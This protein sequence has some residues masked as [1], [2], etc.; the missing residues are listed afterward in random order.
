[1]C[2]WHA[3]E[4]EFVYM[5]QGEVT[6]WEGGVA[7]VLRPGEAACFAAGVAAGH[8]LQNDSAA[9]ARYLVVGTRAAADVVTYPDHDRVYQRAADG[10]ARFTT[11]AGEEAGSAY[12]LPGA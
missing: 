6:L 2:H 11:L 1:L 12:A 4:D 10:T 5:L 8:Y 3:A 7:R 9:E